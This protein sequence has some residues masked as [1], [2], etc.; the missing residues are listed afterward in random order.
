LAYTT[1]REAIP[2]KVRDRKKLQQHHEILVQKIRD[3]NE[4]TIC[5]PR[6]TAEEL[7]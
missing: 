1:E 3:A 7:R 6:C 5:L 4:R 2:Q